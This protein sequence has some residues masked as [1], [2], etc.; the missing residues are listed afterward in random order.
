[1]AGILDWFW[2]KIGLVDPEVQGEEPEVEEEIVDEQPTSRESTSNVSQLPNRNAGE[3]RSETRS[4]TGR[5]DSSTRSSEKKNN[6]QIMVYNPHSYDELPSLV[7]E[8]NNGAPIIVSFIGV[9]DEEMQR[10]LDF[11]F[12]ASYAIGGY[13]TKIDT[14]IYVLA[15]HSVDVNSKMKEALL[16]RDSELANFNRGGS[17]DS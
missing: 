3:T 15:P 17:S 7:K 13:A 5:N 9:S 8:L 1:M 12:G 11:L 2:T 6:M 16:V 10:M 4:E 14:L